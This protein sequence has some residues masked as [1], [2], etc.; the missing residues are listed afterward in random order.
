MLQSR[1]ILLTVLVVPAVALAGPQQA[2]DTIAAEVAHSNA[3]LEHRPPCEGGGTVDTLRSARQRIATAHATITAMEDTPKAT[4]KKWGPLIRA[5][6]TQA[7]RA[8]SA[9]ATA[10]EACSVLEAVRAA[11]GPDTESQVVALASVLEA[12]TVI[13][14][15]VRAEVSD[16]CRGVLGTWA[17][18]GDVQLAPAADPQQLISA[19][20][21]LEAC[22]EPDPID[23]AFT[24]AKSIASAD[25]VLVTIASGPKKIYTGTLTKAVRAYGKRAATRASLIAA[26]HAVFSDRI[27]SSVL[28]KPETAIRRRQ[29][30]QTWRSVAEDLATVESAVAVQ[31]PIAADL[32][33]AVKDREAA[34]DRANEAYW[35]RLGVP[36][37]I[38]DNG[39]RLASDWTERLTSLSRRMGLR[40]LVARV[41]DVPGR[42]GTLTGVSRRV[43]L[44]AE[45]LE[46]KS[47]EVAEMFKD[48]G[49]MQQMARLHLDWLAAMVGP[50]MVQSGQ[51]GFADPPEYME[52]NLR[53]AAGEKL[54]FLLFGAE[55][56]L[57]RFEAGNEWE[58]ADTSSW[59]GLL[60]IGFKASWEDFFSDRG[61]C[62]Q[63]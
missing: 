24:E 49:P 61:H 21:R 28:A 37:G 31:T 6:S 40:N 9:L 8:D 23:D 51:P 45:L 1:S 11:T 5:A 39:A 34:L 58:E 41:S 47:R 12:Q 14:S 33:R 15:H 52:V 50:F 2:L 55:L 63:Q 29:D 26:A 16:A 32:M 38:D 3:T 57:V 46:C 25:A 59:A 44:N 56:S 22:S 48:N 54:H 10:I 19:I 35:A 53:N 30:I 20:E 36:R 62:N 17:R 27:R 42:T 13:P 4:S 18:S 60:S 7:E 43:E